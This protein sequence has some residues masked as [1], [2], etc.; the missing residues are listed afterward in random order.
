MISIYKD[1]KGCKLYIY[2]EDNKITILETVVRSCDINTNIITV[3]SSQSKLNEYERVT[4]LILHS[5]C[6]FEFSGTVR[7]R[8]ASDLTEIALFKGKE[9][10]GRTTKRYPVNAPATVENLVIA[11]RLF[12][13]PKPL[14]A[15]VIN[16]STK[17]ALLKTK[18]AL[19]IGTTFQLRL[20][21]GGKETLLNASVIRINPIDAESTEYGCK[22]NFMYQ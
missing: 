11:N 3:D 18:N 12:S 2:D 9:K 16:I 21:T 17:G 10:E 4:V 1:Y 7:R 15:I 13:L 20:N 6:I 19:N 22:F 14:D 5:Q 8:N